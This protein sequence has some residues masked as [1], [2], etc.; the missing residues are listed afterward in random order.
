MVREERLELSRT[1]HGLL[2]PA[3]L[4]ITSFPHNNCW[5]CIQQCLVVAVIH[6]GSPL[7]SFIDRDIVVHACVLF[8]DTSGLRRFG[9]S[10]R[11]RTDHLKLA[12]LLLSQMSYGPMIWCCL[13]ESNSRHPAYKAGALPT[14]LRQ[15]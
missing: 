13:W 12:K 5:L 2:R 11:T 1:R 15:Q 14:E 8:T 10:S 7:F 6:V 3:W 4:P 9:G